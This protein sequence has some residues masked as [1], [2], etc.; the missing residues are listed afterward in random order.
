MK[1]PLITLLLVAIFCTPL[2]SA[3]Q[4][5]PELKG[6]QIHKDHLFK[7]KGNCELGGVFGMPSG[8]N[9]RYWFIDPF[10][11]EFTVGSTLRRDFIGTFDLLFEFFDLYRSPSLHLRFFFGAG[12]LLGYQNEELVSNIRFPIGL[13]LPFVNHP[14]TLSCFAAPAMVVA[15]GINFD[16]NWGV[17]VRYNFGIASQMMK[18]ERAQS[19]RMRSL[20]DGYDR[21]RENLDSTKKELDQAI[22]ELN[23]T[24]G[25]L[26][27]A[28]GQLNKTMEK[29]Q[30]TKDEL[31]GT[32]S[33]LSST[34]IKLEDTASKLDTAKHQAANMKKELDDTKTQLDSIKQELNRSKKNL[35]D[36]ARELKEKQFELDN[37]KNMMISSELSAKEK[38]EEIKRLSARQDDLNKEMDTFKKEKESWER[39]SENQ[40]KNRIKLQTKCETRRG[41]INED[42]YCDCREHEQWNSDRSAC[43]CVKGYS[44]NQ[45]TDR[46]EPCETVS[47]EGNCVASCGSDE[48]KIPLEKGPHKW[49]CVKKCRKKNEMWSDR[50]NSC[51]CRDG[52]YRDDSG[53][54]V[55]RR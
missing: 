10:G 43:V 35:D 29:L 4:S 51:V 38:E 6:D 30:D 54:C 55:P 26:S 14:L 15:P 53:E 50:K 24:G 27:A 22:S 7:Q 12:T 39:Q 9:L 45:L 36:K 42:G 46:C 28:K 44:L 21:I 47:Y 52:Y 31:E 8:L 2:F 16:V 34:K 17:A 13:S 23:K 32:R 37:A 19:N 3:W 48:K 33:E 1:K 49:I 40:K 11:F 41:I 5:N 18:R 25:E 20:Q